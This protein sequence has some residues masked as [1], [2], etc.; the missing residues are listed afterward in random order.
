MSNKVDSYPQCDKFKEIPR[1]CARK[2]TLTNLKSN[3]PKYPC[4]FRG[5][6]NFGNT[7]SNFIQLILNILKN[8][9]EVYNLIRARKM[10]R[11]YYN[12]F[13]NFCTILNVGVLKSLVG[14]NYKDKSKIRGKVKIYLDTNTCTFN[15]INLMK[16][17]QLLPSIWG[18]RS[19]QPLKNALYPLLPRG[20][21]GNIWSKYNINGKT[22]AY[23]YRP[24]FCNLQKGKLSVNEKFLVD[25]FKTTDFLIR[26][27]SSLKRS[28]VRYAQ[29]RYYCETFTIP[30]IYTASGK[31]QRVSLTGRELKTIYC[32]TLRTSPSYTLNKNLL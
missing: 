5:I 6:Q 18:C 31:K 30:G 9:R 2:E 32:T 24:P 13:K 20:T 14:E 1:C 16:V 23:P 19:N 22:T 29:D 11:K 4:L 27:L 8:D 28:I 15:G 17:I 21:S 25:M 3:K 10:T 7:K 26:V 12:E